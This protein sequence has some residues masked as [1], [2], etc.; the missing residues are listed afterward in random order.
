MDFVTNFL[1]QKA[2]EDEDATQC[3]VCG[4]GSNPTNLIEEWEKMK[5]SLE[6]ILNTSKKTSSKDPNKPKKGRTAYIY[7]CSETREK[8]KKELGEDTTHTDI[9]RELGVRWKKLKTSDD[10]EDIKEIERLNEMVK[11]DKERYEQEMENYIPPTDEELEQLNTTKRKR[12]TTSKNRKP[13]KPRTAYIFFCAELRPKVKERYGISDNKQVIKELSRLW[14]EFKADD[15]LEDEYDRFREMSK[16]DKERYEQEMK[17]YTST[18]EQDKSLDDNNDLDKDSK[19]KPKK[20]RLPA[21]ITNSQ[22]TKKK[23]GLGF[24]KFYQANK[25]DYEVEHPDATEGDI[26]KMLAKEWKKVEPTEK[27]RWSEE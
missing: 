7:Y 27:R 2:E 3:Y 4:E 12:K 13:K 6:K 14:A 23:P 15:E 25:E 26:K 11:K 22:Q 16:K 1:K 21:F 8:L 19:I 20:R 5:P 10:P 17:T 9:M 18:E 24:D